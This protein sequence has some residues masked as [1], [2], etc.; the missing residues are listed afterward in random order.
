MTEVI[1]EPAGALSEAKKGGLARS[2]DGLDKEVSAMPIEAHNNPGFEGAGVSAAAVGACNSH[3]NWERPPILMM[4]EVLD[5]LSDLL[6]RVRQMTE[7]P[8]G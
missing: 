4:Q 8:P 1:S 2:S 7:Q 5:Q 6:P 3:C